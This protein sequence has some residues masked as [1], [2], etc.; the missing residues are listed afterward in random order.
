MRVLA[1]AMTVTGV[2]VACESN[3]DVGKAQQ[4]VDATAS[5][6]PGSGQSGQIR[7]MVTTFMERRLAGEGAERFLDEDGHR[8]FRRGGSLA[9]LYPKPLLQDFRFMFVDDLS[10]GSYEVGVSLIFKRGSYGETLFVH[11]FR[12]RWVVSGGRPGLEGP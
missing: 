2:G 9:P 3:S 4:P 10:D 6:A 1:A 8:V 7:P 12:D 5:V 11:R